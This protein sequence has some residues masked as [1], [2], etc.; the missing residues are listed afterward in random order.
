MDL[1]KSKIKVKQIKITETIKKIKK[2]R[3]IIRILT[4]NG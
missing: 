3:A 2:V 4:E 1:N